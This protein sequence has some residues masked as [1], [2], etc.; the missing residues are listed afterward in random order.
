MCTWSIAPTAVIPFFGV[1]GPNRHQVLHGIRLDLQVVEKQALV[2]GVS[3]VANK[4]VVKMAAASARV[5]LVVLLY[6]R[7][8][9]QPRLPFLC[10]TRVVPDLHF[11]KRAL[12]VDHLRDDTR[13]YDQRDGP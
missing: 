9:G 8:M 3:V 10:K 13:K 6:L 5:P 12:R 2:Y 1:N 7:A 4:V 11:P